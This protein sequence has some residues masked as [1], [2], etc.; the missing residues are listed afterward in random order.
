[1]YRPS[2]KPVMLA[3]HLHK[4]PEKKRIWPMLMSEKF[5]GVFAY[6]LVT[7]NDNRIF[8]RTGKE[9]YSLKHIEAALAECSKLIG[10]SEGVLIFEVYAK[11]MHFEQINGAFRRQSEQF[12]AATAMVHDWIPFDDFIKGE[13]NMT[14]QYRSM[15]AEG[16]AKHVYSKGGPL[17]PVRQSIVF[18]EEEAAEIASEVIGRGGEGLILRSPD[19]GW[20]AGARNQHLVKMKCEEEGTFPV[21]SVTKGKGKY[22]DTLGSV[23]ILVNGEE[24][25]CSGMSDT[26][27]D[28]WWADPSKIVGKDVRVQFMCWTQ[29]GRLREPRLK[30]VL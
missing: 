26:Q 2:A 6:G 18:S 11:G 25:Q 16:I 5:D 23:G 9:C 7:R 19:G 3:K 29:A 30:C 12:K 4:V 24:Q 27:R 28:E 14:F 21:V 13:T 22:A 10:F 15:V 20:L 8:S 17:V 1:M